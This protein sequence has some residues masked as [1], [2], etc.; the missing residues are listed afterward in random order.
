[1]PA[2]LPPGD[3]L[4]IIRKPT[5][6][7][8]EQALT[9]ALERFGAG[10]AIAPADNPD[11]WVTTVRTLP[12][13]EARYAPW[14]ELVDPRLRSALEARGISQLYTHQAAALTHALG[15][16]NVVITTPTASGKTLCYNAPVLSTILSDPAAARHLPVPDQGPRAGPAGRA[17]RVDDAGEPG[18]RD[19][20][21]RLHLR[22]RHAAGRAPRHPDARAHRA[23]Q[24]R[25]AALGDPAAPSEV[26][27]AVRE[28]AVR[29][30]R[31]TACLSRCLRQPPGQ[32]PAPRAAGVPP[33]R[34]RPG[35]HLLVGDDRQPARAGG[36]A[37]RE[38]V[39]A[40][41][42]RAAR[43][44]ARSCFSSSTRPSSTRSLGFAGRILPRPARGGGVPQ[45]A[46]AADRVLSEPAVD[47]D[48]DDISEGR[49][50]RPAG[51]A[52]SRSAD[53]A[54]ATCRCAGARSSAGCAKGR[55]ARSSPPT[56]S[57]SASTSARSTSP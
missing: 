18:R 27:E 13:V 34:I 24:P 42:R 48:P 31:R 30:R 33:L 28:P 25:H 57:S 2:Q 17:S 43:R 54:A 5:G 49:L 3:S 1:M 26:G 44:A 14:P 29:R 40:H 35:L 10:R 53:T 20:H 41:R 38:D 4:A 51:D 39:H 56:R 55:S 46:A 8:R 37:G 45:A 15:G 16:D 47:R 19:R 22:R 11:G 36:A 9:S 50:R 6:P 12:A 7:A 21:R 23:E 32:R 52:G